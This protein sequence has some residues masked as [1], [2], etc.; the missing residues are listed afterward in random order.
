MA[1]HGPVA[2]EH[3]SDPDT[4]TPY[5]MQISNSEEILFYL[6]NS[7]VIS[8]EFR[9][10]SHLYLQWDMAM[11]AIALECTYNIIHII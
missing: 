4:G 5:K 6:L 10:Q 1:P 2:K 3:T 9:G 11:D 7:Q 8:A